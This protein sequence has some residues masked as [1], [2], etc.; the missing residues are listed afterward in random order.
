MVRVYTLVIAPLRRDGAAQERAE[1][2]GVERGA[3]RGAELPPEAARSARGFVA[4]RARAASADGR[5]EG[6]GAR[7]PLE[8]AV[9]RLDQVPCTTRTGLI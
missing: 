7:G 8:E 2:A 5:R 6:A 4:A 9:L 3:E 1:Q